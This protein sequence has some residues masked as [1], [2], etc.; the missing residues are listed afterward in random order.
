MRIV[1]IGSGNLAT[2]LSLALKTVGEDVLQVFSPT[3]DHAMRLAALLHCEAVTS[4]SDVAGDADMY[5]I[6]VRDD[7]VCDVARSLRV[8]NAD[9]VVVHTAGSVPLSALDGSLP[10]TAVLYPMQTFSRERRIDFRRVPCFVEA[11]DP[12]AMSIVD[13]LARRLSDTVVEA[14]SARRRKL[15]LAA[16]FACNMSNHCYRLAERIVEDEGFS[17]RLFA[18][19][20]EETAK[21]IRCM[22]PRQAQTGPMVRND[23]S[24]MNAQLEMLDDPYMRD[25]YRLMAES[26][27]RDSREG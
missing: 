10:H 11:S 15:H 26:I 24:V 19:L 21:K 25:I 2:Q 17:F 20:I 22:S 1:M 12:Y 9:S 5:V 16:V 7:A 23:V 27:Y 6:S 3:A 8:H 18:P 4:I 13:S 14:D